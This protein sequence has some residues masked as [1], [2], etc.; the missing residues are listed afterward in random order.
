MNQFL[1]NFKKS[2]NNP[3]ISMNNSKKSKIHKNI[4]S[5]SIKITLKYFK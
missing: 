2:K 1:D 4:K 5:D 3:K